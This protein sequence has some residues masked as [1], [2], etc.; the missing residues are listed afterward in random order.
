MESKAS[1]KDSKGYYKSP[2]PEMMDH[3][4][5]NPK[6]VTSDYTPQ[7]WYGNSDPYKSDNYKQAK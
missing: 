6:D 7:G 5:A 2:K 4:M 3:G 1:T